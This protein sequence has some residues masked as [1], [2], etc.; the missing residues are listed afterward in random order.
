MANIF[1]GLKGSAGYIWPGGTL[2]N[3]S[4]LL[5]K[6]ADQQDWEY[7]ATTMV[8]FRKTLSEVTKGSHA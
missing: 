4:A 3:S 5:E 2:Q 7:I 6:A 8:D 1:H